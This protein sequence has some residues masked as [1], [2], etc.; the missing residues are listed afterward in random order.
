MN[1]KKIILNYK[2]QKVFCCLSF[3]RPFI[4]VAHAYSLEKQQRKKIVFFSVVLRRCCCYYFYRNTTLNGTHIHTQNTSTGSSGGGGGGDRDVRSLGIPTHTCIGLCVLCAKR[5][6]LLL[7][8]FSL[9]S[10]W[11]CV[12]S[13]HVVDFFCW[14]FL[15]FCSLASYFSFSF[16]RSHLFLF[17][18][19][20]SSVLRSFISRL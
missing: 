7:S 14:L 12:F 4:S 17:A 10:R 2:T 18:R 6:R 8:Y 15:F 16:I 9:H 1:M 20:F 5:Q 19:V 11:F 13:V 3:S